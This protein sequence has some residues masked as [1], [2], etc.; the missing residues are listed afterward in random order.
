MVDQYNVP[1]LVLVPGCQLLLVLPN[2][3]DKVPCAE[4]EEYYVEHE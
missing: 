3:V 4:Q 1:S 2:S